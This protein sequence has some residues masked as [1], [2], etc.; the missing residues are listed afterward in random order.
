M[1]EHLVDDF[2]VTYRY[3]L[4]DI[5]LYVENTRVEPIDPLFLDPQA[6]Y[7]LP[8]EQGGAEQTLEKYIAVKYV[9]DANTG[10]LHLKK[11]ASISELNQTDSELGASESFHY[12]EKRDPYRDFCISARVPVVY[13]RPRESALMLVDA[14]RDGR[15]ST[16]PATTPKSSTRPHTGW[17]VCVAG[18]CIAFSPHRSLTIWRR[19]H[20]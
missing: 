5:E 18:K 9:R 4:R 11:V 20:Q 13:L 19:P 10:S 17:S 3:L 15:Y 8:Q 6:R 1:R 16:V 14:M 12:A 2:G 7:F